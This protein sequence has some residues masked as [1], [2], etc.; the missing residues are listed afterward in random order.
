MTDA[1]DLDR[2]ARRVRA[3][4]PTV[5]AVRLVVVD[6]PAGSGKTTVAAGLAQ[7]LGDVPVVHADE[8]YE[9]W[10]VVAGVEDPVAAFSTLAERVVAQLLVPWAEDRAGEHRVW[11]WVHGRWSPGLRTVPPAP[12]VVL[13][14]VGLGA[15]VLRARA[16]AAVWVEHPDAAERL[17]RVL[18]RD[19]AALEERMRRWQRAEAAWFAH[20]GT[21]AGSTDLVAT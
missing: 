15:A 4:A 5:G 7:R 10:S 11:D 1:S 16:V 8:L 17:R 18:A 13:E 19:G 20:D 3:A 21:R 9:G 2:L 14:G 6:G 12:V